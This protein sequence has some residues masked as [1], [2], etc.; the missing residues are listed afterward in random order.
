VRE[1]IGREVTRLQQIGQNL[2]SL[3]VIL[4][5]GE[6]AHQRNYQRPEV[7]SSQVIRSRLAAMRSLK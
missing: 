3:D 6:L 1:E 4:S 5:L 2:A 7:D